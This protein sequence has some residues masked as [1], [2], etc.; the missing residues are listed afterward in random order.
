MFRVTEGTCTNMGPTVGG[1]LE[2][3]FGIMV[4]IVQSISAFDQINTI[5]AFCVDPRDYNGTNNAGIQLM[6]DG[7]TFD[8]LAH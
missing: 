8:I 4:T 7:Y 1:E 3:W 5:R 2:K 6:R